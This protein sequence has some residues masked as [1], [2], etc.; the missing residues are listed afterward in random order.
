[1]EPENQIKN[2]Q[3]KTRLNLKGISLYPFVLASIALFGLFIY[4]TLYKYDKLDQKYPVM[5]NR[6][7]GEAKILTQDG[8]QNTPNIDSALGRV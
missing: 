4:P 7:T 2:E 8:W 1:M 6:L 5:I 3:K